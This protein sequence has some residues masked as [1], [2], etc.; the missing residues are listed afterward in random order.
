VGVG[1]EAEDAFADGVTV[2][3]VVEEPAIELG[4]AE[5]GLY[6]VQLHGDRIR[7]LGMEG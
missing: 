6:G 5:S 1:V 2:M 7:H 3:M 4:V